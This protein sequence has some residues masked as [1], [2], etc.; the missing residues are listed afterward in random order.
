MFKHVGLTAQEITDLGSEQA[1]QAR[2]QNQHPTPEMIARDQQQ[3]GCA[4]EFVQR[5]QQSGLAGFI[6]TDESRDAL[7]W[8]PIAVVDVTEVLHAVADRL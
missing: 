7:Q 1:Q 2:S 4:R 5:L 3:K 8:N 6:P